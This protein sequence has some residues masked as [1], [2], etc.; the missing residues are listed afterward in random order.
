MKRWLFRWLF[1]GCDLTL[2]INPTI[3]VSHPDGFDLR[4]YDMGLKRC[5]DD[6]IDDAQRDALYGRKD[7]EHYDRYSD[8]PC[9][10]VYTEEY[11]RAVRQQEKRREEERREEEREEERQHEIALQRRYEAE[12]EE[13]SYYEEPYRTPMSDGD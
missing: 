4:F 6:D 11:D 5:L 7:Y 10:Q 8:D 12:M 9:K 3:N 1:V 2:G 13:S